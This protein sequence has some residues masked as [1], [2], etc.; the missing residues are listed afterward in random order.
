MNVNLDYFNY[1]PISENI[2]ELFINKM[3]ILPDLPIQFQINPDNFNESYKNLYKY[4][5]DSIV[6]GALP[7]PFYSD[8]IEEFAERVF[9]RTNFRN[10]INELKKIK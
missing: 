3:D 5:L 7:E 8:Y 10:C 1:D 2:D 9:Y 4:F 6:I